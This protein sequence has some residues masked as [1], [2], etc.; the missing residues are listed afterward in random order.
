MCN[1]AVLMNTSQ[2]R[3]PIPFGTSLATNIGDLQHHVA[4]AIKV[5]GPSKLW[6]VFKASPDEN[7][8]DNYIAY[9]VVT[10]VLGL[11]FEE[12]VKE[13]PYN[14]TAMGHVVDIVGHIDLQ[15]CYEGQESCVTYTRFVVSKA[16]DKSYDVILCSASNSPDGY[17]CFGNAPEKSSQF[18]R[19]IWR[20]TQRLFGT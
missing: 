16:L 9:R 7:A 3:N 20:K 18:S 17:T 13:Q 10:E 4:V 8:N 1:A 6:T 5:L 14:G 15:W 12:E 11:Q 19:T 2:V